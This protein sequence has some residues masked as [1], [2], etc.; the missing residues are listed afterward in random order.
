MQH[1]GDKKPSLRNSNAR[2]ACALLG[3]I[4]TLSAGCTTLSSAPT[5]LDGAQDGSDA[6][7]F[8]APP[9]K[10]RDPSI[11]EAIR[12]QA[13]QLGLSTPRAVFLFVAP[14]SVL[15]PVSIQ[16]DG[17]WYFNVQALRRVRF[18]NEFAAVV[19]AA[20][21]IASFPGD[22]GSAPS[23][24]SVTREM[25]RTL[26]R[27][28]YDPRGAA[29]FW[30]SWGLVVRQGRAPGPQQ[31]RWSTLTVD[32]EDEAQ[33]EIAKLPPLLNPVVR[34]QEFAKIGKRLQKL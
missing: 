7:E 20:A 25:V 22:T 4:F 31:L 18:E 32:L 12:T 8:F 29:N 21:V 27:G 15:P 33:V 2:W 6:V 17:S 34:T 23:W 28:G 11:E 1:S 19:A 16:Q 10:T 9:E 30:K 13:G 3:I 5:A 24:R 26:Y 14:E